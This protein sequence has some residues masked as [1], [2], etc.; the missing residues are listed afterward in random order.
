MSRK[1]DLIS[2]FVEI[3]PLDRDGFL[4]VRETLTRIGLPAREHEDGKPV[5][6]QTCHILHKRG[7]YYLCHFKQLFLLDGRTRTTDYTKE[8]E[9]RLL[10]IASLLD[11][12]GLVTT[13]KEINTD[14]IEDCP[15]T[16]L[17]YSEKH[18]WTLKQKYTIGTRV[19]GN[20]MN[21][22]D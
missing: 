15:L 6:W 13:I 10:I 19:K 3:E 22:N 17:T 4:K 16:V 11:E 12:W 18:E 8:D 14:D 7:R 2:T 20:R 5:L 9:S 21:N 1:S